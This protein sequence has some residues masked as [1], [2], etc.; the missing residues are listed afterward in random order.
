MF[1]SILFKTYFSNNSSFHYSN[2]LFLKAFHGFPCLTPLT[3]VFDHIDKSVVNSFIWTQ[4][5][6]DNIKI[7][8]C[9]DQMNVVSIH[10]SSYV[11]F[12][13]RNGQSKNAFIY[14]YKVIKSALYN[15]IIETTLGTTLF[16]TSRKVLVER[17]YFL[18]NKLYTNRLLLIN[19]SPNPKA[20]IVRKR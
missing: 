10:R 17:H 12:V 19:I 6:W 3:I 13:Y 1:A 4:Y 11:R 2:L 9:F 16:N 20:R 7:F 5:F 15:W 8:V 18:L 14:A